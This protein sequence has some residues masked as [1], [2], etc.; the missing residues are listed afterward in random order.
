MINGAVGHDVDGVCRSDKP[1]CGGTRR[2]TDAPSRRAQSIVSDRAIRATATRGVRIARVT[3][4][5]Y[6]HTHTPV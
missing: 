1:C 2:R 5:Q 6:T 4:L 3:S